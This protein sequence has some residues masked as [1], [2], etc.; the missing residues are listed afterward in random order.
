MY[1]I[2]PYTS[3]SR[4]RDLFDV[5]DEFFSSSRLQSSNLKIDVQD[6]ETEYIIEADVPGIKKEEIQIHF[7]NERLQIN[8]FKEELEEEKEKDNYIHRERFVESLNRSVYLKD[9]DPKK[10][11]A[12]LEDGVLKIVAQKQKD[13]INKYMIKID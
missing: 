9:V 3:V 6:F 2:K 7:E 12:S 4:N 5:F 8:I 1:R 10:F 13:K 11:K